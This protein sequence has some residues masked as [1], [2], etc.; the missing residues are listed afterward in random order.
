MTRRGKKA[1]RSAQR[2]QLL[3]FLSAT[4]APTMPAMML[5]MRNRDMGLA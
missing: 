2:G 5:R 3:P 4:T 1:H